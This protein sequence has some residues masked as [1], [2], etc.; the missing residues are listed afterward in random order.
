M[1][2]KERTFKMETAMLNQNILTLK[3][4]L[5]DKGSYIHPMRF[6]EALATAINFE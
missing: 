2:G 6:E 1:E 5:K 3:T 4:T